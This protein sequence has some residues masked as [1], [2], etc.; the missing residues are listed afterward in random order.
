M[1]S[2][3]DHVRSLDEYAAYLQARRD[4]AI[5]LLKELRERLKGLCGALAATADAQHIELNALKDRCENL[6]ERL[7]EEK[8][9][10]ATQTAELGK[11]SAMYQEID[12]ER[13]ELKTKAEEATILVI[14][15]HEKS[16]QLGIENKEL[17]ILLSRTSAEYAELRTRFGEGQAQYSELEQ[18]RDS[19]AAQARQEAAVGA[20][21]EATVLRA[22]DRAER[23]AEELADLLRK[24]VED[25][26][27]VEKELA[28]TKYELAEHQLQLQHCW[29]EMKEA[30]TKPDNACVLVRDA[31]AELFHPATAARR[32][33]QASAGPARPTAPFAL[34]ASAGAP[35]YGVRA[36][37]GPMA[38]SAGGSSVPPLAT[39][40]RGGWWNVEE[41]ARPGVRTHVPTSMF[42]PTNTAA[43]RYTPEYMFL[44]KRFALS[45]DGEDDDVD[46]AL[47][48]DHDGDGDGA[49]APSNQLGGQPG[50]SEGEYSMVYCASSSG[51]GSSTLSEG[52]SGK[53]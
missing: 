37:P 48:E 22:L 34:A 31:R 24:S 13:Q 49:Q 19:F 51:E 41:S 14:S 7:L 44:P 45:V 12:G 5:P 36:G 10:A 35:G 23:E 46:M 1:D 39:P 50:D 25:K 18:Q 28:N 42:A 9:L 17:R 32:Q 53:S 26:A 21:N 16:T 33:G 29:S 40:T 47:L 38:A 11:W 2:P 27:E 52:S 6:C 30:H 15:A 4:E 3:V 20:A 8:D 43:A